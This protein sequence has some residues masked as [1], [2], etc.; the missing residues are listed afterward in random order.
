MLSRSIAVMACLSLIGMTIL[1]A[2]V[3]PCCCKNKDNLAQGT[4]AHPL[5]CCEKSS[6]IRTTSEGT[7]KPC[8][9][10]NS[11]DL[12]SCC[13]NR[14]IKKECPACRCLEQMQIIALSGYSVDGSTVRVPLLSIHDMA[15]TPDVT[16]LIAANPIREEGPPG[17]PAFVRTCTLRC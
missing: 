14:V 2:S 3:I 17:N 6:T 7:V 10:K 12:Q 11:V 9:A 15:S 8:C 4:F 16:L 5:S 13:S 1:P